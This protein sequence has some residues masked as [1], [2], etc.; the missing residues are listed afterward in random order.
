M[1]TPPSPSPRDALTELQ[2]RHSGARILL[3]EDNAAIRKVIDLLLQ[4]A[5]LIVEF[6]ADGVEA[7]EK[8][9]IPG[10]D[11]I[12]MDMRMP[13]MDGLAATRAIR[14]LPG[15]AAT[16]IL[17]V[18]A[19]AVEDERAAC[20]AAGMN[21]VVGKPVI[22]AILYQALLDWLD[23]TRNPVAAQASGVVQDI[24]AVAGDAD[25]IG[26][27]KR[28]PGLDVEAGLAA[29]QGDADKL[30]QVLDLFVRTHGNDLERLAAASAAIS[31][32]ELGDLAHSL[33]GAAGMVGA[34]QVAESARRLF[35][36]VGRGADPAEVEARR[37]ELAAEL[38][39][40]IAALGE[41]SSG[42]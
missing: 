15:R 5:G 36:A 1:Q 31:R 40:L 13:R 34:W 29:T 17:A 18:T 26:R 41:A 6:A 12:L 4:R 21:G 7:L 39:A 28:I 37:I 9:A 25:S 20:L 42:A 22:P 16:P 35:L 32:A 38:A 30:R 8:A 11:L 3:A 24:E 33:K 19:N 23:A 14:A 10:C 27:L 2:Q